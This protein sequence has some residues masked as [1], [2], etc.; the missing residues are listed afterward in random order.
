MGYIQHKLFEIFPRL[1]AKFILKLGKKETYL[2][3]A[4]VVQVPHTA[5]RSVYGVKFERYQRELKLILLVPYSYINRAKREFSNSVCFIPIPYTDCDYMSTRPCFG[6]S[7]GSGSSEA[8]TSQLFGY[9]SWRS[10][11]PVYSKNTP[12]Q[13]KFDREQAKIGSRFTVL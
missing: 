10:R 3:A 1:P 4:P 11:C 7:A 9:E 13:Y 5:P 2:R 6:A 12:K 8:C